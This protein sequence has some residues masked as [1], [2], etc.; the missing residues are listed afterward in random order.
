MG[1]NAKTH[2]LYAAYLSTRS[3][4]YIQQPQLRKCGSFC[5]DLNYYRYSHH[6]HHH[7]ILNSLFFL[8]VGEISAG[9][10]WLLSPGVLWES[11]YASYWW[12]KFIITIEIYYFKQFISGA[13]LWKS[14]NSIENRFLIEWIE[15]G[16]LFSLSCS[17]VLSVFCPLKYDM[18]HNWQKR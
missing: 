16:A 2:S 15:K 17:S 9:R 6:R 3:F 13:N 10:L 12:V 4:L 18:K 14:H 11:A 8:V 5:P 1:A 7:L